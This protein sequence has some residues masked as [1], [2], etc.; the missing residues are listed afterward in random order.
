MISA[1]PVEAIMFLVACLFVCLFVCNITGERVQLSSYTFRM[2]GRRMVL[3][4]FRPKLGQN[5]Q[6]WTKQSD[7]PL[8]A[9]DEICCDWQHFITA[10]GAAVY[11]ACGGKALI[12]INEVVLRRARSVVGWVTVW[13]PVNHLTHSD[14]LS[15]K[16]N[17]I[18]QKNITLVLY[19]AKIRRRDFQNHRC[20]FA[21]YDRNQQSRLVVFE[22]PEHSKHKCANFTSVSFWA[23]LYTFNY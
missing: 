10:R 6:H 3:G 5:P 19:R 22:K 4:L 14:W 21:S 1:R 17:V 23:V 18:V 9:S 20:S 12:S 2:D 16:S 13:E 11:V 7:N 15:V 8:W